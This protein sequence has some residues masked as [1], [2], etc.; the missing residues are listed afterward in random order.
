MTLGS[1]IWN[2][3]PEKVKSETSYK[4]LRNTLIYG[5]DPNVDEHIQIPLQ[6]NTSQSY[7]RNFGN[8]KI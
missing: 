1:K 8:T 5:L 6:L 3:L 4:S 7:Y 2:A